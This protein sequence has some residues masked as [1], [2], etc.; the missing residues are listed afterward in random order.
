MEVLP[1]ALG[2]FHVVR[3]FY[4][5][6]RQAVEKSRI[7]S[8]SEATLFPSVAVADA[9]ESIRRDAVFTGVRIPDDYVARLQEFATSQ[10]L[11]VKNG[12]NGFRYKDVNNG[13]LHDGQVVTLAQVTG[14]QS[15]PIAKAI[16]EDPVAVG[17]MAKYL[18]YTPQHE[19][20]LY[21]S[22]VSDASLEDRRRTGQ[23]VEYHYDCHSYNFAYAAYYLTDTD[24]TSGAHVMVTGSHIDKPTAWLFGS[25][26]KSDEAVNA[27]YSRNRIITIGG[28][29]GDGFWQDSSCYHKALA[30]AT[31]DRLLLQVRY[32]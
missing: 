1:Y 24:E 20:R 19:I 21:W 14:I 5:W 10:P 15:H 7:S 25:T 28:N 31:T 13:R 11:R 26:R 18:R 17:V 16:A 9:V 22:F 32:C 8:P 29:A 2:R 3:R 27:H 4:S 23:T 12:P 6:Q 30:P